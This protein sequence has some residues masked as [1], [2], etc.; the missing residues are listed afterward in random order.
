ML[1]KLAGIAVAAALLSPAAAHARSWNVEARGEVRCAGVPMAGVRVELMH[2]KVSWSDAFDSVMDGVVTDDD[3]RWQ[4]RGAGGSIWGPPAPYVRVVY[5]SIFGDAS[6]PP[7]KGVRIHDEVGSTHSN[8]LGVRD[9]PWRPAVI[10]MGV[11]DFDTTDC[12]LWSLGDRAGT[13]YKD[14]IERVVPLPYTQLDIVRWSGLYIGQPSSGLATIYWPTNASVEDWKVF[15]EFG[16]TIRHSLDGGYSHFLRD[17]TRFTYARNHN[18]CDDTNAGFAFNEGWATLWSTRIS[19]PPKVPKPCNAPPLWTVQGDVA[20]DLRALANC[21]SMASMVM[22]LRDNPGAIHTRD[23]FRAALKQRFPRACE[24]PDPP[25]PSP[26][27]CASGTVTQQFYDGMVGCAGTVTHDKAAT[28]C[29]A[30]FKPCRAQQWVGSRRHLKPEHHY[31]LGEKIDRADFLGACA[32][33]PSGKGRACENSFHICAPGPKDPEGNRCEWIDCDWD[34]PV[35]TEFFTNQFF[36]G[37]G[38]D[39][40]TAGTLC[41][42]EI[43]PLVTELRPAAEEKPRDKAGDRAVLV[44]VIVA[45]QQRLAAARAAA[46]LPRSCPQETGCGPALLP[47]IEPALL[48]GTIE[49]Y[50]LHLARLDSS[51]SSM[52]EVQQKMADGTLDAWLR[53]HA[54]SY[55]TEAASIRIRALTRAI[56]ALEP[57]LRT[58]L[59]ADEARLAIEELKTQIAALE[60]VRRNPDNPPPDFQMF[61]AAAHVPRR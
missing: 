57:A 25:Q 15:H 42:P 1:N 21:I 7:A 31:W 52:F 47:L 11:L 8:H 12:R 39:N 60:E 13:D 9:F 24:P 27:G 17:A 20:V 37:C 26:N 10:D 36:G 32:G 51:L 38:P 29:G 59:L 33:R 43:T 30:G 16:H 44:E 54:R 45:L 61:D 53:E 28:L 34:P 56:A 19:L 22:V 41:C 2:S 35:G 18:Q 23:E 4:M 49:L 5:T 46:V 40:T 48:E 14:D 50:R 58:P 3:G 6:I 55:V